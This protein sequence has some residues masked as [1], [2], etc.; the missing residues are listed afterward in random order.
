[1]LKKGDKVRWKFQNGETQGIV[2]TIH[3]SD[4]VFMGRQRR[5]SEENPQYE[6]VSEKTGKSAVHKSSAL[7]KI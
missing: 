3:K 2:T 5:A 4:F 7:K 6:V 1:M